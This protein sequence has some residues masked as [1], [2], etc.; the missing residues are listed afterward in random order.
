MIVPF[1]SDFSTGYNTRYIIYHWCLVTVNSTCD[2]LR[3]AWRLA[4]WVTDDMPSLNLSFL[5]LLK[6]PSQNYQPTPLRKGMGRNWKV[7]STNLFK[8]PQYWEICIQ[9]GGF[10]SFVQVTTILDNVYWKHC[11]LMKQC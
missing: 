11:H 7:C 1:T 10:N 3:I 6:S 4:K 9:K 5:F 8:L 2:L